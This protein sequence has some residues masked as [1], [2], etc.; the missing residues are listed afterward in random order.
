MS[1]FV[2]IAAFTA[3]QAMAQDPSL[4]VNEADA[5]AIAITAYRTG[6]PIDHHIASVLAGYVQRQSFQQDR[7]GK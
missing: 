2:T 1:I 3:L 4:T 6:Q 5:N 7:Y